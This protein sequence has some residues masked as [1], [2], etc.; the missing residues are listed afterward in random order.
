MKRSWII[1]IIKGSI[2]FSSNVAIKR[3]QLKLKKISK[4]CQK[5]NKKLVETDG[6][7]IIGSKKK[8]KKKKEWIYKQHLGFF[9]FF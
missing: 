5:V 4:C 1:I 6:P 3:S 9:F 2:N 8:K 7:I